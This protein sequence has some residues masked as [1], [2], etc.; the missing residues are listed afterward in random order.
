MH[1]VLHLHVVNGI[2]AVPVIFF[3][4]FPVLREQGD[5]ILVITDEHIKGIF[6]LPGVRMPAGNG[7]GADANLQNP[8]FG[9][10]DGV[11]VPTVSVDD[12]ICPVPQFRQ[13]GG[14]M[15]TTNLFV[16]GKHQPH[17]RLGLLPGQFPQQVH[18][19]RI[20]TF[21]IHTAA[22]VKAVAPDLGLELLLLARYHIQMPLEENSGVPGG[23][24][25][26]YQCRILPETMFRNVNRHLAEKI[27]YV[28]N[29]ALKLLKSTIHRA[30]SNQ[31]TGGLHQ[32]LQLHVNF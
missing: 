13:P 19:Q 8:F 28:R 10:D 27:L 20:K 16:E 26:N 2:G 29:S 5:D 12:D 31:V 18:G 32:F 14:T 9:K 3:G 11:I 22:S 24:C 30:K 25:G 15:L 23:A 7:F 6:S 4:G 1:F 21:H 17:I